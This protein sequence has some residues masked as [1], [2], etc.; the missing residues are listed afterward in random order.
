MPLVLTNQTTG[1]QTTITDSTS[2]EQAILSVKDYCTSYSNTADD[3]K[4]ILA[5]SYADS[6]SAKLARDLA[7]VI[8]DVNAVIPESLN[9]SL[10]TYSFE[11]KKDASN[12]TKSIYIAKIYQNVL[13]INNTDGFVSYYKDEAS[14]TSNIALDTYN[15]TPPL[16]Q[17]LDIPQT[18]NN[19]LSGVK[20]TYVDVNTYKVD[21][22][23][24]L[25]LRDES[26][27]NSIGIAAKVYALKLMTDLGVT[28]NQ[29]VLDTALNTKRDANLY[30]DTKIQ[31]KDT[32]L[33]A[34]ID[35]HKWLV[36]SITDIATFA[37]TERDITNVSLQAL[38]EQINQILSQ[39]F[40]EEM[41]EYYLLR[42]EDDLYPK[43]LN[44]TCY[45]EQGMQKF[46]S[47][48][49]DTTIEFI[50][51]YPFTPDEV[52]TFKI[53]VH[54]ANHNGYALL[55]EGHGVGN[56]NKNVV[57]LYSFEAHEL[58]TRIFKALLGTNG[59]IQ[60]DN[61][62]TL[63][64]GSIY[65]A[66]ATQSWVRDLL[67]N[68]SVDQAALDAVKL[69]LTDLINTKYQQ[70]TTD[71][72]SALTEAKTYTDQKFT[73]ISIL[74]VT[75]GYV[76]NKAF[77]TLNS[78]K[79]YADTQDQAILQS[80]KS[81]TKTYADQVKI[82]CNIYANGK[83][84][85]MYVPFLFAFNPLGTYST[86]S[87][88]NGSWSLTPGTYLICNGTSFNVT[89]FADY[90]RFLGITGQTNNKTPNFASPHPN[91]KYIVR[92]A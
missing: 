23:L 50:N 84:L 34:Y 51:H 72:A 10:G 35:N 12:T 65:D 80:S 64:T 54:D 39:V 77:E 29:L 20:I 42:M 81:Y 17:S 73:A 43:K 90:S 15:F 24:M 87:G 4:L 53:V 45:I 49:K 67:V 18:A 31:A 6:L 30:T 60:L 28:F 69:A 91:Y 68:G 32:E 5:K 88:T 71:I 27:I 52:S 92:V 78:A 48:D 26:Y 37:Q 9:L 14:F 79:S 74:N 41:F 40:S 59:E 13:V 38:Q 3:A 25:T 66:V 11:V 8:P 61:P 46:K 82:D 55:Y 33:K 62:L 75:Q 16:T 22:T 47:Y 44:Q 7:V 70:T 86:E 89:K 1:Q 2:L 56:T 57:S 36:A 63:K 58:K 83:S 76:D 21:M 85:P 19:Y